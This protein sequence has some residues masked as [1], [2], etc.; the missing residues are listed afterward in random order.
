MLIPDVVKQCLTCSETTVAVKLMLILL[1]FQIIS[2]RAK[3]LKKEEG[4]DDY[5]YVEPEI[6]PEGK[7]SIKLTLEFLAKN[8][9]NPEKYNADYLAREY[10]LDHDT[11]TRIMKYYQL[12]QL[13]TPRPKN[14]PKLEESKPSDKMLDE[15]K[16]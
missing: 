14:P 8:Q 10:K 12:F 5:G 2:K 15:K 11:A 3:R 6:I 1:Q 7:I 4:E 16:S 13:Y 9:E